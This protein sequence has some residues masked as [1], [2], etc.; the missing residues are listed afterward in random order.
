MTTILLRDDI[1][2]KVERKITLKGEIIELLGGSGGLE[3]MKV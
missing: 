2:D 1:A 3:E